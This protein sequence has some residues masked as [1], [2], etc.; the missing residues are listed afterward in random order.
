MVRE[1]NVLTAPHFVSPTGPGGKVANDLVAG[2]TRF[3]LG[4]IAQRG[5]GQAGQGGQ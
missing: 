2:W 1:G 3:N 4:Q 5:P